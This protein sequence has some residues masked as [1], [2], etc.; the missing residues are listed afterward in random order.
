MYILPPS[1]LPHKKLTL[2]I[3][4]ECSA[5]EPAAAFE[6]VGILDSL[7]GSDRHVLPG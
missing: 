1:H 2:V 4:K 6:T 7:R 3:V 5:F